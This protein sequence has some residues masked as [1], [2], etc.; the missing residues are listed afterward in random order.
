[1]MEIF[2]LTSKINKDGGNILRYF[3]HFKHVT[4][5]FRPSTDV[6]EIASP[7]LSCITSVEPRIDVWSSPV[8]AVQFL[9]PE[10]VYVEEGPRDLVSRFSPG[11]YDDDLH[12]TRRTPTTHSRLEKHLKYQT[13]KYRRYGVSTL[14]LFYNSGVFHLHF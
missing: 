13:V 7:C 10:I 14:P 5:L 12:R 4:F 1:M 2:F 11:S 8:V 6:V 9:E 3:S